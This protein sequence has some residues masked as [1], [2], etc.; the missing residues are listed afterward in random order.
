[1]QQDKARESGLYIENVSGYHSVK[2]DP[3]P[4]FM[5]G[6]RMRLEEDGF[7]FFYD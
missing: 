7:S 2:I 3:G 4:V 1:M 6:L 5:N